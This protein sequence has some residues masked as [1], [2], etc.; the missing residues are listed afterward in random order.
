M[1]PAPEALSLPPEL[2]QSISEVRDDASNTD[3]CL[4][5]FDGAQVRVVGSGDGGATELASNLAPQGV[6]YGLVRTTEHID[7]T[8]ATKFVFVSFIGAEVPVMRRAKIGM[9][10]GTM[11]EAFS[12]FHAELINATSVDEITPSAIKSLLNEMW[13]DVTDAKADGSIRV[14][15]KSIKMDGSNRVAKGQGSISAR[16]QV[17]IPDGLKAAIADVRSDSSS[18]DWA[19]CGFVNGNENLT[20]IGSGV[21]GTATLASHLEPAGIYYGLVRTTEQ[22]DKSSTVK[23]VFITVIDAEVPAM[24]KA[25]IS[26]FK[27]TIAEE[28]FAPFH[29][30]LINASI[31]E[32]T[33]EAIN[34]LLQSAAGKTGEGGVIAAAL[35][36]Q[37]TFLTP[38]QRDERRADARAAKMVASSMVSKAEIVAA[39]PEVAA[40]VAAVRSNTD[41]TSWAVLGYG[42]NGTTLQV[43]G[44]GSNPLLE[45]AM[46]P[47]LQ[48]NQLLYALVRVVHMV[49]G[50]V[51]AT[52]FL[53]ISWIGEEVPP[54]RKA[55]LSVLR[56]G[57]QQWLSPYSAELLNVTS[58]NEITQDRILEAIGQN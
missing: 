56:G 24:R 5:V 55:K 19:L 32:V 30:E 31:Q 34:A 54:L 16:Q 6:Y 53:M 21:G 37:E 27:G 4:C 28:I 39:P 3:W 1:P 14:G 40:V 7:N 22:I 38:R 15:M 13:G 46:A 17:S 44:T 41:E 8:V 18:T 57:V 51:G 26:T 9:F 50:Q 33:T 12:P 20:H 43:V 47:L 49:D 10:K 35:P 23:F 52:K 36:E 48:S 45:E 58:I 11:S 2:K 25:K 42:D 29:A